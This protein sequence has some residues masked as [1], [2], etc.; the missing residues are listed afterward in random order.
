M[1][2]PRRM[3]HETNTETDQKPTI[4]LGNSQ[5]RQGNPNQDT[6]RQPKRS[7][8]I[9]QTIP[10]P[11]IPSNWRMR[12]RQ[13]ARHPPDMDSNRGQP[14]A[15]RLSTS[16]F[17]IEQDQIQRKQTVAEI[18]CKPLPRSVADDLALLKFSRGK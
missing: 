17:D 13:Q 18:W 3:N 1:Q 8:S 12:T 2:K 5:N 4:N 14:L 10:I 9:H 6:C 15:G 16:F 11:R 7:R